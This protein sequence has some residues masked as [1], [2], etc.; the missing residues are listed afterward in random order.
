MR[1]STESATPLGSYWRLRSVMVW[2]ESFTRVPSC[3]VQK[4][5]GI[6]C[7]SPCAID[8]AKERCRSGQYPQGFAEFFPPITVQEVEQYIGPRTEHQWRLLDASDVQAFVMG[9][10]A[11]FTE[12][13]RK[14]VDRSTDS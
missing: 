7:F 12:I 14:Q 3:S 11:L 5:I 9:L 1:S 6:A 10:D 8:P 13:R 2:V 4:A